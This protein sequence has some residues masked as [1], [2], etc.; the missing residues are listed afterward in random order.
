MLF[1]SHIAVILLHVLIFKERVLV[2]FVE[3]RLCGA[4]RII[5]CEVYLSSWQD[6]P[7]KT[8]FGLTCRYIDGRELVF[9]DLADSAAELKGF[10]DRL[11]GQVCGIPAL[12]DV[13]EDF[14]ME[15]SF[16]REV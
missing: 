1:T 9:P 8:I 12:R 7:Q 11:T 4:D 5:S 10:A 6:D 16:Y 15:Q 2:M 3:D 13:V 14:V